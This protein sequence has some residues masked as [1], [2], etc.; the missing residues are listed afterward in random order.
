MKCGSNKPRNVAGEERGLGLE[1]LEG[2]DQGSLLSKTGN[3]LNV[4]P[5]RTA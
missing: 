4:T 3:R 2:G 1:R 5:S